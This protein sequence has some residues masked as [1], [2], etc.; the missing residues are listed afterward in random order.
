MDDAA[1][2]LI[3]TTV[4][5]H[6]DSL[7]RVARMLLR[8]RTI[9]GD[10]VIEPV[11]LNGGAGGR[12]EGGG[13]GADAGRGAVGGGRDSP[14]YSIPQPPKPRGAEG[15]GE[16]ARRRHDAGSRAPREAARGAEVRG[17]GHGEKDTLK[18]VTIPRVCGITFCSQK[19]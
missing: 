18:V 19:P 7:L 1:R 17:G 6:A 14:V 16:A 5:R 4:Q 12:G 10:A 11:W 13:G 9:A 15:G 3:V 2:S 8:F